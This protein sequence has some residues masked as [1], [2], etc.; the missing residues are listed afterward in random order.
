MR[1][2]FANIR[3][4]NRMTAGKEG[5]VTKHFPRARMSIYDAAMRYQ[6][7]GVPL[8]VFAGKEYGTGSSRDW[9]AKGTRLLGVRAVIAETF[10]RIH[11]SNLVGMGVLPLQF[12]DGVLAEAGPDRRGDRHHPRPRRAQAAPEAGGGDRRRRRHARARSRCCA[13]SIPRRSWPTTATAASCPSCCATWP[14]PE[15]GSGS[16]ARVS[17]PSGSDT[18]P[19]SRAE[20]TVSDPEGLGPNLESPIR[21]SHL[22]AR[23]QIFR[24]WGALARIGRRKTQCGVWR[25]WR[26]VGLGR[27]LVPKRGE[28]TEGGDLR[29][30]Q[31]GLRALYQPGL[32]LLPG[33][34]RRA[35]PPGQAR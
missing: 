5:G 31:G 11:R 19:P 28:R 18:I 4:R 22:N 16:R 15:G 13:G 8:V 23:I 20:A 6:A 29:A 33:S 17:E 2:T 1:G 25:S 10:E 30:D 27:L 26:L 12:E 9:A 21:D 3:I 14:P 7:E 34:R 24:D 35:Q 32:L